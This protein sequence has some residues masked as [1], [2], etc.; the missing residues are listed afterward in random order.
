MTTAQPCA[1]GAVH[2]TE[3]IGRP[4]QPVQVIERRN[5]RVDGIGEFADHLLGDVDEVA[6]LPSVA[7]VLTTTTNPPADDE[8]LHIEERDPEVGDNDS[9]DELD[10]ANAEDFYADAPEDV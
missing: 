4:R 10:A 3:L 6:T 1:R 7:R 9:E 5:Y 2:H 8:V